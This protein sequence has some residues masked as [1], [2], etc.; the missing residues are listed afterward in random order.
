MIRACSPRWGAELGKILVAT[1]YDAKTSFMQMGT[2]IKDQLIT[3]INEFF[4]P[5]LKPSTIKAKGFPKPLI[6]TGVMV[7]SPNFVVED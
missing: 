7:R 2:R 5:P 4:D 1:G 6:D 3:S